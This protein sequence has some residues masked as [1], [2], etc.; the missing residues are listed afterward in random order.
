MENKAFKDL[1]IGDY[2]FVERYFTEVFAIT[3]EDGFIVINN[4]FCIPFNH[5]KANSLKTCLGMV[6]LNAKQWRKY[7]HKEVDKMTKPLVNH[8]ITLKY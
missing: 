5:A 7:L 3:N 6:F 2:I 8:Q 4:V 1:Q